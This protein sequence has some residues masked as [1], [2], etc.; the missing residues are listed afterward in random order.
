MAV[1][2]KN[3]KEKYTIIDNAVFMDYNLSYKA[4]GL[5]CQMLSLP[6]GW[7]WS[8]EGLTKLS[9][10]GKA[11]VMSALNELKDN[12]YFYRRQVREGNRISGIEYVISEVKMNDFQDAENQNVENQHAENP[13][14]LNTNKL[15]TDLLK[16]KEINTEFE[17]LWMLYPRKQGKKKALE[18]YKSARKKGVTYEDVKHGI[19]AYVEYIRVQGIEERYIKQGS[20]F[21]SQNAWQDDW[22]PKHSNSSNPFMAMLENGDFL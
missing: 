10:D 1:L 4:K 22:T 15:N 16:T 5:L 8:I 12:G 18:S 9:S 13:P 21:F 2:R 14:Q 17:S 11:S 3:K 20:T 7:S 6:D 19:E